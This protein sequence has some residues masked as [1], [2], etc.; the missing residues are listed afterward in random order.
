MGNDDIDLEP[1]ELRCDFG[2]ALAPSFRPAI[3]N[4]DIAALDPA[5]LAQTLRESGSPCAG[6]RRRGR[7]QKSDGRHLA[8]LLRPRREWPRCCRA[9]DQRYELA[10]VH[11]ITSSAMASSFSGTVR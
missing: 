10:A 4:R 5:E 3:F 9:A 11:S 2:K 6:G 8:C 7:A 1:D